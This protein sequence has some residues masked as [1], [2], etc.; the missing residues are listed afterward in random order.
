MSQ[1]NAAARTAQVTSRAKLR[2]KILAKFNSRSS[3]PRCQFRGYTRAIAQPVSA[4]RVPWEPTPPYDQGAHTPDNGPPRIPVTEYKCSGR[5]F[6][7][8]MLRSERG[9]VKSLKHAEPDTGDTAFS[10]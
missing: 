10:S 7:E 1:A 9:G 5:E 2:I 3:D 8:K 4:G 6:S